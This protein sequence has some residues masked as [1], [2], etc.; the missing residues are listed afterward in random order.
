MSESHSRRQPSLHHGRALLIYAGL[1][2]VL[3][4]PLVT[5]FATHVPGDGIDDPS[6]T[7]NLWWLKTRLVDQLNADVFHADWMFH[8]VTINLGFYTLTPLNGLLSI[9]L[10]TA[11]SLV[12]AN[13]LL[14]ILAFVLAGYGTYLLAADLLSRG[15]EASALSSAESI[16]AGRWL[17]WAALLAGL[18]YA[19]ASS[20][21]FYASLG[22]F[23]IA[24]SQWIPFCVFY[25]IRTGRPSATWRDGAMAGIFLVFQAWAELTYASF[26]LIFI[27]FYFLWRITIGV[28]TGVPRLAD[29][30]SL[31][32]RF[33]VTAALFVIGIAPFL[34]A[35]WPDLR[36]EDD[37][38]ASGGGFADV[39][40]ADLMGYLM[41]TRL[42]PI[43]GAWVAT[44][45]FPND[46]GQ[47]IFI[48]YL[49]LILA[50]IGFV[51]LMRSPSS[52]LR[53]VGI[54]WGGATLLFWL[55]T[56]GPELRWAG[57]ALGIPGP[58][59]LVSRLPIFN[60]NRYP[61][62]YSVMLMLC[63][64]VLAAW[65]TAWLL[66]HLRNHL[67]VSVGASL[68]ALLFILEHFSAPLPLNDFRM[69][70]IFAQ[71]SASSSDG[72]LLEL[73]TGWRNGARVLGRSDVVIMMQQWYQTAHGQRRLGGNTSR[74]PGYKFQ[75]FSEA[76]LIGDLIALM[77]ADDSN[78]ATSHIAAAV[79]EAYDEIVARNSDAAPSILA[80]LGVEQVM[81]Y[82]DHA[83][84][85]LLRF[86]DEALP[87][88]LKDEWQ[89]A[90]W[91]GQP[92]T[93][94]LYD[95]VDRP[96]AGTWS[97]D[98]STQMGNLH[99]AEGW[100]SVATGPGEIRY[101]LRPT[102][103]LLLDLPATAGEL[104]LGLSGPAETV[105][106]RLNG[107]LLERAI[108]IDPDEPTSVS[109]EIPSGVA[110]QL[111][112]RLSLTFDGEPHAAR[113]IEM[114][115][116]AHGWPIGQ[117]GTFLRP[118]AN[119]VVRSAGADVGSFA[120]IFVNGV[121]VGGESRGYHL[122][123]ISSVGEVLASATFDTFAD[124]SASI[125]MADWIR[126]WPVGTIIAGAVADEASLHLTEE[127]VSALATL[128]VEGDLRDRF[129][130]SHVLIGVT[131]AMRGTA[132]EE[133]DLLRPTSAY[134][135]PA[136]TGD[137]VYGG[138]MI[139]EYRS[140]Q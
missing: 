107:R 77:N 137:S 134:V 138:V 21:L 139:L 9:P 61:S 80:F 108:T 75:Y 52:Q 136:I 16:G 82:V 140:Q 123:A 33:L 130:W 70:P 54:L 109:V 13:N 41:P 56:L 69:P 74:N 35:M 46:K 20:K 120:Q 57:E 47:H 110:D 103:D 122:A 116:N 76:P 51:L 37:L 104:H 132:V 65:G 129:R 62:R 99:L 22:Q 121:D 59:A 72:T 5:R 85:A 126:Q 18:I 135:G 68:L 4:W 98:L 90:D 49:A 117:T 102:A 31:I 45:P 27:A 8:P 32:R 44:Q 118:G 50:L 87:L 113:S 1:A 26:L 23:N 39:F 14:L 36:R 17:E 66:Q 71:V 106:L 131:G 2:L 7:W 124:E 83:T 115:D 92:S 94:R 64:A 73:P 53:R 105:E 114:P 78:P 42:H 112:D 100:S 119:V 43:V 128:G 63:V 34:W 11:F 125:A 97:I 81:V 29:A 93:L 25:V 88:V 84:P 38:F 58:F 95:V 111:V 127:A 55:L 12:I 89:G 91:Q 24:S 101:A 60:G 6:L 19:F 133:L 67:A 3:T 15:V 40:S 96:Q 30:R 10:Q 79:D 28:P 48:G 86:I